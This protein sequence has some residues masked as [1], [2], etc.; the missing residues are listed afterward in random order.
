[1]LE[2]RNVGYKEKVLQVHASDNLT[3]QLEE[4]VM[5]LDEVV[6]RGDNEKTYVIGSP[7]R[8]RGIP[9]T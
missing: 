9:G 5:L 7:K 1:R 6:V 2:F 8:P 3:I 4:R